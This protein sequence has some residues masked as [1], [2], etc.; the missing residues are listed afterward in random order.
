M[1]EEQEL[2]KAGVCFK[3]DNH[4]PNLVNLNEDRQ[5]SEMLLYILKEGETRVGSL[6][7]GSEH[8]I[9]LTGALISVDH[10]VITNVQGV[11]TLSPI[12]DARTFVNGN[13]LVEA[14]TLHHRNRVILGGNHYF[15]FN[16]PMEVKNG[17]RA[18]LM[19][20]GGADGLRD[21]EFAKNELVEAQKQRIEMEVEEAR[22]QAQKE[23]MEEL[24]MAKELAQQELWAQSRLIRIT[25]N[26][27]KNCW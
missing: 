14:V 8:N 21:F 18:S 9:Q 25:S 22:R 11:V 19:P 23:M 17:R 1:E 16:H 6:H 26:S 5:L 3:A 13:F 10:C 27:W 2:Q 7:P 24:Q 4:L 15:R 12:P 20:A